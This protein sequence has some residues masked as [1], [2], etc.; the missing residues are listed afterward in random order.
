[1]ADAAGAGPEIQ[2]ILAEAH[3]AFGSDD[4]ARLRGVL[5]RYPALKGML[6]EPVGPFDA[7]VIIHVKSRGMLDALLDAGADINARSRWWAG[8]FGVLDWAPSEVAVYAIERGAT[9]TIHAAARLG[10]NDQLRA[11]IAQDPSLVHARSRSCGARTARTAAVSC[12]TVSP[13]GR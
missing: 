4:V 12:R 1:M 5:S 2:K 11:F 9:L 3:E 7:P 6:N 10:L 13:R 8:G